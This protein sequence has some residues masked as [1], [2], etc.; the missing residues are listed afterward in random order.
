MTQWTKRAHIPVFLL[1]AWW[2]ASMPFS[3]VCW[4]LVWCRQS[5][6]TGRVKQGQ[7][8]YYS[9][10]NLLKYS[11]F[12]LELTF[13]EP[14]SL[15]LNVKTN[16]QFNRCQLHKQW[17]ADGFNTKRAH[18]PQLSCSLERLPHLNTYKMIA[19]YTICPFYITLFS[20]TI[21]ETWIQ[22]SIQSM[23]APLSLCNLH[24]WEE[25]QV[26]FIRPSM[27]QSKHIFSVPLPVHGRLLNQRLVSIT[28]QIVNWRICLVNAPTVRTAAGQEATNLTAPTRLQK[29]GWIQKH[30][31]Q[32][33]MFKLLQFKTLG[34]NKHST[35]TTTAWDNK[36]G[37]S[38]G[39]SISS[40]HWE[41]VYCP[42]KSAPNLPNHLN[43]PQHLQTFYI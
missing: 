1:K 28:R 41:D 27:G 9:L 20:H 35:T 21:H 39:P 31:T 4:N 22:C 36:D 37:I 10:K 38:G 34:E 5:S 40:F 17:T 16:P 42:L 8:I 12:G 29:C 24:P 30:F 7:D 15:Q 2:A 32:R 18:V 33:H 3:W 25:W 19:F 13:K 14:T 26:L 43:F 6:F 11:R 23:K